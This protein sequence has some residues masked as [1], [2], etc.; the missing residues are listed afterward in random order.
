M[1]ISGHCG[2]WVRSLQTCHG[3]HGSKGSWAARRASRAHGAPALDPD[4][5]Y[6]IDVISGRA[7]AL[8]VLAQSLLKV[9]VS[10][11]VGAKTGLA[12][13]HDNYDADRLAPVDEAERARLSRF[14]RCIACG[15][16]DVG[17]GERMARSGGR[18]PGLMAI[19]LASSRSMPDF[20][21]A[22]IALSYVPEE[23][24]A[25]KEGL[26]P[27]GVPFRELARFVRNKAALA[28]GTSEAPE[29]R[30]LMPAPVTAQAG[31]RA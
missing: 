17:E 12:L 13:F 8:V 10:R 5:R 26:C 27:T 29:A 14:S 24:L 25:E 7:L 20:D 16:C 23:V 4:L 3:H 28:R 19:T 18:Y 21:A 31:G 15:R 11:M 2:R 22:E 1:S 6:E 9:L 30:E